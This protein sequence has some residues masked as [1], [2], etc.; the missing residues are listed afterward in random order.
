MDLIGFALAV[1]LIELTPGPNMGWLVALT[2]TE[3]RRAG[4][5]AISGIALGLASN[6]ALSVLAASWVLQQSDA[7]AQGISLLGA[8]MMAYLAWQAWRDTGESSPDTMPFRAARHHA[9]AG[10]TINL[11]NPKATLF[12]VTVMPQFVPDG[13]PTYAQG[14]TMA[15]ISVA[16]ATGI[17]LALILGAERVRPVLMAD[18]RAL[19]VRRVLAVGMLGV[20]AWF[21]AKAFL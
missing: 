12:F 5:A 7:L 15:A 8:A 16:I 6:A 10:F 18:G 9:L 14:L 17:H 3:G 11:L 1:L 19:V 2:L 20:G 21:L 13:R 4:L